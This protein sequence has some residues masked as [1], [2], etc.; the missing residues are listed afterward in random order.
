M[1]Y[2]PT[3]LTINPTKATAESLSLHFKNKVGARFQPF[4]HLGLL[5]VVK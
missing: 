2:I 4:H 5:L 3:T 1:H